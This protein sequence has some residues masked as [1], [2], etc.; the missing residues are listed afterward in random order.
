MGVECVLRLRWLIYSSVCVCVVV[1]E[2][3][4]AATVRGG[5]LQYLYVQILYSN[6]VGL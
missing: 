6:I 1:I 5:I 3:A 4:R 2:N